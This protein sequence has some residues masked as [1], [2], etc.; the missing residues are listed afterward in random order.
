MN[1]FPTHPIELN[2][3]FKE[4]GLYVVN[5]EIKGSY[6]IKMNP[7]KVKT[8]KDLESAFLKV[9]KCA[10]KFG[11]ELVLQQMTYDVSNFRFHGSSYEIWFSVK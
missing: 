7:S 6:I 10:N 11:F 5:P 1:G 9:Q 4:T 2:R 8:K 3:M